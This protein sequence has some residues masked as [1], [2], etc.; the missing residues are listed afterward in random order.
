M[1]WKKCAA[2]LFILAISASSH[3]ET[4][5][6][7]VTATPT[8]QPSLKYRL[9]PDASTLARG[10]ALEVYLKNDV[11]LR[12]LGLDADLFGLANGFLDK[13]ELAKAKICLETS[14][15]L[16]DQA[17]SAASFERCEF[18]PVKYN[19]QLSFKTELQF[20]CL[21][22][23]AMLKAKAEGDEGKMESAVEWLGVA[24][25]ISFHMMESH[26][27]SMA[28]AGMTVERQ[29]ARMA[30]ELG[31]DRPNLYWP[32][33]QMPFKKTD[34]GAAY[35]HEMRG[36]KNMMKASKDPLT[37]TEEDLKEIWTELERSGYLSTELKFSDLMKRVLDGIQ[38][39]GMA[40]QYMKLKGFSDKQVKALKP[41]QVV[42]YFYFNPIREYSDE[43]AKLSEMPFP[44]A[45]E[46]CLELE[47]KYAKESPGSETEDDVDLGIRI[48]PFQ[49]IAGVSF[50]GFTLMLKEQGLLERQLA[51]GKII[52]AMRDYAYWHNG[53]LP[54]S[55][56]DIKNLL[57]DLNPM[58]GKAFDWKKTGFGKGTLSA[59][60]SLEDRHDSSIEY[61]IEIQSP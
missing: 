15:K 41:I 18:D 21:A 17:K 33:A 51:M 39:Q 57:V 12:K 20:N 53:D 61:E 26:N 40:E 8:T 46:K 54:R 27:E 1:I 36:F 13:D 60:R 23:T 28:T 25:Q 56:D 4:R 6:I 31:T 50:S 35:D 52:E 43:Y 14:G 22:W 38:S 5:K 59:P 58:T 48:N 49:L 42:C 24:N 29:V 11:E 34:I 2:G 47:K 30:L 9:T 55:L 10:N 7:T 45:M 44:Y 3:A 37:L 19:F 16:L 32:I